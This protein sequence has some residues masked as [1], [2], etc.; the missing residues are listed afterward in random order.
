MLSCIVLIIFLFLCY[1]FNDTFI[2]DCL[3]GWK[4]YNAEY[5]VLAR[6]ITMTV[7][8]IAM[9]AVFVLIP[10]FK[11][12]SIIG[13]NTL[14]IYLYHNNLTTPCSRLLTKIGAPDNAI[15]FFLLAII[16]FYFVNM[17]SKIK[18]LTCLIRPLDAVGLKTKG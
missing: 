6:A 10:D 8:L 11:E 15:L 2:R 7:S 16:I 5:S 3:Y 13:S 12:K 18:I 1:I 17:L 14:F 9:G 4:C